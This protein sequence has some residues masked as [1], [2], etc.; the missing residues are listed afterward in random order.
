MLDEIV[1][2]HGRMI[3]PDFCLFPFTVCLRCC[4]SWFSSRPIDGLMLE[5]TPIINAFDQLQLATAKVRVY[6]L[7]N[8]QF[9]TL[10]LPIRTFTNVA[11][12]ATRLENKNKRCAQ[13]PSFRRHVT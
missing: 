12:S 10:L 9:V 1:C 11:I 8:V 6:Y 13:Y 5:I 4:Y 7:S 2:A 3:E